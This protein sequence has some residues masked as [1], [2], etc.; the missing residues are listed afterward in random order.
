MYK[1]CSEGTRSTQCVAFTEF[2]TCSALSLL[3][4]YD[5]VRLTSQNCG[6]YGPVIHPWVICSVDHGRMILTEVNSQLV[7]QSALAATSTVR[8]SCQQR[9]LWQPPV[10]SGGRSIWDISCLCYWPQLGQPVFE[11][12]FKTRTFWIWNECVNHS[13]MTFSNFSC[14][15]Q[16]LNKWGFSWFS[17]VPPGK[18]WDTSLNYMTTISF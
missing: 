11:P 3:I 2:T 14:N 12:R 16:L 13:D 1:L 15:R 5:G 10:L 18:C 9:H 4:G 17:S 6:L 8:W 7:Y